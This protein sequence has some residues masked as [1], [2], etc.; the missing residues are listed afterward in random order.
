MAYKIT[1]NYL[2]IQIQIQ[3]TA[4]SSFIYFTTAFTLAD[5]NV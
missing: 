4:T 2:I 5:M 1:C 3:D